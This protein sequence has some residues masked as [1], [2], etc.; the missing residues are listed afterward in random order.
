MQIPNKLVPVRGVLKPRGWAG[1][2]SSV[3]AVS[4]AGKDFQ[5]GNF[6][7]EE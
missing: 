3:F 1:E 5:N 4:V 2:C 6:L 7:E